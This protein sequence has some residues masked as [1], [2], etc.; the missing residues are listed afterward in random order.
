MWRSS[1]GSCRRRSRVVAKPQ[2]SNKSCHSSTGTLRSAKG[3]LP[4]QPVPDGAQL[5][6]CWTR[7]YVSPAASA[8]ASECLFALA[9]PPG[10]YF[11][12]GWRFSLPIRKTSP[13]H[14]SGLKEKLHVEMPK[15]TGQ[16]A[17]RELPTL[18]G[19]FWCFSRRHP[20]P[21]FPRR[22]DHPS[23]VNET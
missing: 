8:P 11:K 21:A 18:G 7:C 16:R 23:A 3:I 5:A 14:L 1:Q 15:H 10:S 6:A 20:Q 4:S 9:G 12:A 19:D 13:Q 17:Q 2:A 22:K